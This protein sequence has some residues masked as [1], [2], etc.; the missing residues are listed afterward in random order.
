[1][2]QSSTEAISNAILKYFSGNK[3]HLID[4][5]RPVWICS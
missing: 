2:R 3:P 5:S 4:L 1:M